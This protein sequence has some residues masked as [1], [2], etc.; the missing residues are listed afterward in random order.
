MLSGEPLLPVH[1]AFGVGP[2]DGMPNKLNAEIMVA[3]SDL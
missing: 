1:S 2:E 3:R